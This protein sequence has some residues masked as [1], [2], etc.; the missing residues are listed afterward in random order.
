VRLVVK[1]GGTLLERG[2][3]RAIIDDIKKMDGGQLALVHG[4]GE[5]VTEIS[6]K[7]GKKTVF[8]VSPEGIKSRYTDKETMEIFTMV[9]CGKISKEIVLALYSA[10]LKAVSLSGIDGAMLTGIRKKKLMILNE[11]GRKMLID[12]GYTGRVTKV[13]SELINSIFG[14][15]MIPVVSPVALSSENELLN[16]DGDRAASSLAVGIG[17]DSA[18]FLTNVKG[19]L[20]HGTLVRRLNTSSARKLLPAVGFGMQKKVLAGIEAVDGGVTE[21]VIASGARPSP[22]SRALAHESCTVISN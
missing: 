4:G 10:G 1:V 18:I 8:I 12:G 22:I 20:R 19:L 6:E 7:L 14:L 15:N 21:A 3:P 16:L 17:A 11:R 13:N 5:K 9:M 2:L